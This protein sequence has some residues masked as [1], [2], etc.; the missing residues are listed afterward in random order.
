[1]KKWFYSPVSDK[2]QYILL[3]VDLE[4]QSA[5]HTRY[6]K[7]VGYYQI[8]LTFVWR[9]FTPEKKT[10]HKIFEYNLI[11]LFFEYL[12]RALRSS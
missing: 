11:L 4:T 7:G 5:V 2:K 8:N 9:Y 1:M 6:V 10:N 3:C 12:R